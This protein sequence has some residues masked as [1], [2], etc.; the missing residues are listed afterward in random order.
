MKNNYAC[1]L[2]SLVL[3]TF[4]CSRPA[5]YKDPAVAPGVILKSVMSFL[6]YRQENINLAEDF[7]AMDTTNNIITKELFLTLLSSGEYLP[8]KLISKD[9]SSYYK[10]HK[11]DLSENKEIREIIKYWGED[12]YRLYKMEGKE[13]PRFNFVDLEG[14]IYNKETTRGKLLVLKCWFIKCQVCIEEMPALNEL[15]KNYKNRKDIIF[16]SLALD[17]KKDLQAFLKNTAFNYPVIADQKNY[18]T[19]TLNVYSFPTH[20][21]IN[22]QGLIA[23][24]VNDY[25]SMAKFLHKEAVVKK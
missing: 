7:I 18:I 16:V 1:I 9:S 22:K 25:K 10:L 11:L 20:L 24:V 12:E 21:V 3:V 4:S 2:L 14:N 15:V 5:N 23:K 8:L 13:L 17:S 6:I 19:E